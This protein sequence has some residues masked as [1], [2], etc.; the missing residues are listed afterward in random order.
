[1]NVGE[2]TMSA[3]SYEQELK[4]RDFRQKEWEAVV[5]AAVSDIERTLLKNHSGFHHTTFFG[6]MGIDPK[7]LAIWCF[8]TKDRDLK[9]AEDENFTGEIQQATREALR[10]HGYPGN[11]TPSVAVSFATDEEVQ[12]TCGGN[13]WLFLK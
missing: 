2:D 7:H 5:S 8:F 12:R 11:L 4:E 13:Y 10:K 3:S 6:A 1:M 9:N